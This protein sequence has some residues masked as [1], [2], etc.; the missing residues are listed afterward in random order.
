MILPRATSRASGSQLPGERTDHDEVFVAV[1]GTT[2]A[3]PA[4]R[5]IFRFAP[6]LPEE[7]TNIHEFFVAMAETALAEPATR[8]IHCF[9][10]KVA[11][12]RTRF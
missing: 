4:P 11:G 3:G 2:L 5:N 10:A 6:Q 12:E 9:R 1:S 8:N 7:G